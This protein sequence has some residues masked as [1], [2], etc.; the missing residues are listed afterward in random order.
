MKDSGLRVKMIKKLFGGLKMSWVHV[1]V[2]AVVAGVWTAAMNMIP[3]TEGTS[4][5]DIAVSYEWWLIFA[6]II[7]TNCEKSWE[8]ALKTFVFF[9]ISQPL[10]FGLEV[11]FGGLDPQMAYYYIYSNWGPKIIMTLPGG[12]I[13]FFIKKQNWLGAIILGLGNAIQAILGVAYIL[14]VIKNPPFHILTVIISFASIFI[15]TWS[16]QKETKY[17]VVSLVITALV[18][19]LVVGY[20]L[21]GNGF[22]F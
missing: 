18:C 12:F 16:V 5:R 10:I 22:F 17:R 13:A 9:L 19:A 14:E 21:A 15:M 6:F 1:I 3:I 7:A 8:S 4:F 11:V 20:L 2:F